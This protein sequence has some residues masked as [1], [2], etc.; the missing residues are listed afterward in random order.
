M[1]K[2]ESSDNVI[3][4]GINKICLNKVGLLC[5]HKQQLDLL[6]KELKCE[7]KRENQLMYKL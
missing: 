2:L 4:R 1:N 3:W 7:F 5:Q 6:D